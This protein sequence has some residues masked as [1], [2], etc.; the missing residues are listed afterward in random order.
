M[1]QGPGA[2]LDGQTCGHMGSGTTG[3]GFA[4]TCLHPEGERV[5]AAARLIATTIPPRRRDGRPVLVD[6]AR[7]AADLRP[8]T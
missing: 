4:A 8:V 7:Q 2:G 5:M 3:R 6:H 1:G